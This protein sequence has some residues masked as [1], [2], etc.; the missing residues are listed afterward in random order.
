MLLPARRGSSAKSGRPK[1]SNTAATVNR[2]CC[3]RRTASPKAV[4][5]EIIAA[6]AASADASKRGWSRP[7]PVHCELPRVQALGCHICCAWGWKWARGV[8]VCE[9]E[10]GGVG[11]GGEGGQA[12][13]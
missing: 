4:G 12:C 8:C 10:E 2:R 1:P 9:E 13:A 6:A 11:L 5:A 7:G 3:R